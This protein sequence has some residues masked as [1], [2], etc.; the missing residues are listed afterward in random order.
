MQYRFNS[1]VLDT[2]KFALYNDGRKVDI[3]PQVLR[4]LGYLIENRD[5]VASRNELLDKVFG[6][7]I[8][9]DNALTVRIRAARQ[10]VGDSAKTNL[11]S[12]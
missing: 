6:R 1:F 4:L 2:A 3:E 9:T 7:R 8:V 10:A 12:E 11:G 5:R